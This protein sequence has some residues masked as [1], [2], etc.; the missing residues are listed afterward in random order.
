[1]AFG[2][3]GS[4]ID[5]AE[6]QGR[7]TE[8]PSRSPHKAAGILRIDKIQASRTTLDV[9]ALNDLGPFKQE[10]RDYLKPIFMK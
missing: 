5:Q 6:E 9:I 1:M 2:N 4:F 7:L 10:L 3:L 8:Y